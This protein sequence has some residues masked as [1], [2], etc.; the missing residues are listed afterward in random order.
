ML[1]Y[2][3]KPNKHRR[4]YRGRYRVNEQ[5]RIREVALHTSVKE[6]AMKRLKEIHEEAQLEDAGLISP[7]YIRKAQKRP[8]L[9]LLEEFLADVRKRE[10]TKDY[11][12]C[13]KMRIPTVL[14]GCRWSTHG[15]VTSKGFLDWRD[16]QT[17]YARRTL[18]HFLSDMKAFLNWMER[19][20]EI[21]NPL[22]RIQKLSVPT[23][24]D[25][26][27]ALTEDELGRLLAA[28]PRRSLFYRLVAFS[29]LRHKEA[30]RLLWGDVRLEGNDPGF[31]LRAEATKSRRPDRLPIISDLVTPL[32]VARPAF[33][34]AQTPVFYRGVPN[35][36]TLHRDIARAGIA[37]KD[38]LGRSIGFH[39]F[40]RTFISQLQKRG[41]HS[42]VIMQLA[43][44]KSLRMT[45]L[46]YTDTTLLPLREGIESLAGMAVLGSP[47]PAIGS[48]T[49]PQKAV[50][51]GIELS[52]AGQAEKPDDSKTRVQSPQAEALLEEQSGVG[53]DC[54]PPKM[55]GEQ[56]LEPW[57]SCV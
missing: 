53:P 27:R 17:R 20:Y 5:A 30:R 3:L 29:G 1:R 34:T 9:E 45:D 32:R 42:R 18:N 56:G 16:A 4:T 46:T 43:R 15:D 31:S 14:E 38:G 55:V 26:P 36:T 35:I 10:R 24:S 51:S 12:D 52:K 57:T 6:V 44:H 49:P 48:H 22:K 54:P 19:T 39:T 21:K 28:A 37:E 33:A 50:Q 25:G 23:N 47:A 41:I 7:G 11:I 40:R 8:L 2:L 13:L